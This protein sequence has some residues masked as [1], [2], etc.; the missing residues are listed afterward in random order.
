MPKTNLVETESLA[1]PAPAAFTKHDSSRHFLIS[2]VLWKRTDSGANVSKGWLCGITVV[3]KVV[4]HLL[5]TSTNLQRVYAV[6]LKASLICLLMQ[7][8]VL[9]MNFKALLIL[10]MDSLKEHLLPHI[11]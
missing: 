8:L 7:S 2:A 4:A 6:P 9:V 1:S 10:D 11:F 5:L 3:Q